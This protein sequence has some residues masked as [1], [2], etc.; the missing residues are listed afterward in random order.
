MPDLPRSLKTVVQPGE[1]MGDKPV[2]PRPLIADGIM[3]PE[4]ITLLYGTPN[5]GKG[6]IS[7]YAIRALIAEG[8][9]PAVLDFE[10]NEFEWRHRAY[11]MGIRFLRY[12]PIGT[13]TLGMVTAYRE[14]FT[15]D[16]VTHCIIDS[17]SMARADV[18]E[19]DAGG[20]DAT[21]QLFRLLQVLKMPILMIG[22]QSV[23]GRGTTPLGSTQFVAQ[24]RIIYR[25]TKP[26][27]YAS[28]TCTKANEYDMALLGRTF[29]IWHNGDAL[30]IAEASTTA[31]MPG[32]DTIGSLVLAFM[33]QDR[34]Y[35]RQELE[36]MLRREGKEFTEGGLSKTLS[37]LEAGGTLSNPKR[38]IWRKK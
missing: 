31:R 32:K 19:N 24:S 21:T 12:E 34:L 4:K 26:D 33:E 18:R 38:G 36:A 20:T 23:K 28:L 6:M 2:L 27:E 29:R 13:L 35:G 8:F 16:G 7:L 17:A 11:G 9:N 5:S 25:V 10:N 14:Q 1:W 22:H 3:H 37:N 15:I 30:T